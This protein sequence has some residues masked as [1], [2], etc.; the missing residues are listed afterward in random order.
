MDGGLHSSNCWPGPPFRKAM[1][2]RLREGGGQGVRAGCQ[3]TFPFQ[4][5]SVPW[6]RPTRAAVTTAA[7]NSVKCAEGR[8]APTA[9][10]IAPPPP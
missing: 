2:R 3:R 4:K 10:H 6:L 1:R 9:E 8:A 7:W 5:R